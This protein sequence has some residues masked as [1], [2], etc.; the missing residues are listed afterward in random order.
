M[1]PSFPAPPFEWQSNREDVGELRGELRAVKEQARKDADQLE[2]LQQENGNLR[3]TLGEYKGKA[4][5]LEK[6]V[7][8]LMAPKSPEPEA[9]ANPAETPTSDDIT[10]APTPTSW[11]RRTFG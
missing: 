6:Q 5:A 8:Q 3:I 7:L 1:P 2:K 10:P 9:S 4:E 11:W